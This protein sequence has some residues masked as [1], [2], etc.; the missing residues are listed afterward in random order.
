MLCCDL[1]EMAD[2]K[3]FINTT[4]TNPSVNSKNTT[5]KFK[6][7]TERPSVSINEAGHR[8]DLVYLPAYSPNLN[9]IER[10]WKFLKKECLY[11]RYYEKFEDF[12][13]AID[14]CVAE[15]PTRYLDK[16]NSSMTLNFHL[17][18]NCPF[19]NA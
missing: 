3:M 7:F 11:N 10:Y 16:M 8:I 5:N 2:S 9:L 12:C 6:E 1:I 14:K 13:S 19:L 15:T 4:N 18:E 17:F